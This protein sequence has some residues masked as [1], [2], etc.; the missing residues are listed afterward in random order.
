MALVPVYMPKFGMTMV[1][2]LITEWHVEEGA[3]VQQG[4]PLFAVETEKASS[5][6]EAAVSGTLVEIC[7]E[8]ESEA[9][10]G[11]I[12]AYIETNS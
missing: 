1:E 2:G 5:D 9:A 4:E 11:A 6:V 10:V 12:V 8:A 7:A 3:P